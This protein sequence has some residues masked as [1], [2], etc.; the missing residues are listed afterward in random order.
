MTGPV[1]DIYDRTTLR[2]VKGDVTLRKRT[3]KHKDLNDNRYVKVRIGTEAPP[4]DHEELIHRLNE[5]LVR[6]EWL[7][8]AVMQLE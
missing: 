8:T 7:E 5:A 1:Y 3:G 6:I 4:I 2:L